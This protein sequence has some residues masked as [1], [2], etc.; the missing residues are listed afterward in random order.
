[1][2]FNFSRIFDMWKLAIALAIFFFAGPALSATCTF[3]AGASN[4]GPIATASTDCGV[5]DGDDLFV[6]D[7]PTSV[8]TVIDDITFTATVGAIEGIQGELIV[9]V[10]TATGALSI[11]LFDGNDDLSQAGVED[12][13]A[14]LG[15]PSF[16]TT[17]AGGYRTLGVASPVIVSTHTDTNQTTWTVDAITF[18]DSDCTAGTQ[19][20]LVCF[21]YTDALNDSGS[22]EAGDNHLDDSIAAIE[23]GRDEV[24]FLDPSMESPWCYPVTSEVHATP[25]KICINTVQRGYGRTGEEGTAKPVAHREILHVKVNGAQD[26][27]STCLYLDDATG[28]DLIATGNGVGWCFYDAADTT[29][30]LP[31]LGSLS[32]IQCDE[33]TA[34]DD[35]IYFAEEQATR[36]DLADQAAGYIGPCIE[37]GDNFVV[38]APVQISVSTTV[39]SDEGKLIFQGPTNIAATHMAGGAIRFDGA[40]EDIDGLHVRE[41]GDGGVLPSVTLQEMGGPKLSCFTVLGGDPD[42][43]T[44]TIQLAL[45]DN[46]GQVGLYH[47]AFRYYSDDAISTVGSTVPTSSLRMRWSKFEQ[48]GIDPDIAASSVSIVDDNGIAAFYLTKATL[49]DTVCKDCARGV[50]L[51]RGNVV[52]MGA[53]IPLRAHRFAIWGMNSGGP[54]GSAGTPAGVV[55]DEV[56]Y[57]EFMARHLRP[58]GGVTAGQLPQYIKGCDVRDVA[59]ADLNTSVMTGYYP[60]IED[61]I[62]A[63]I[64][65]DVTRLFNGGSDGTI[66]RNNIFWN[67]DTI[68]AGGGGGGLCVAHVTDCAVL[69][70]YQD[71]ADATT[72][73]V[74][75]NNVFGWDDGDTTR[76]GYGVFSEP[77]V[78]PAVEVRFDYGGNLV[79]QLN[80]SSRSN[81]FVVGL[82]I[83]SDWL[84]I[85][86]D[87][88]GPNCVYEVTVAGVGTEAALD[89]PNQAVYTANGLELLRGMPPKFISEFDNNFVTK[90]GSFQNERGCGSKVGL[91]APGITAT[92]TH[93]WMFDAVGLDAAPISPIERSRAR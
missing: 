11:F 14:Y 68:A 27:G 18:C 73:E 56:R 43:D 85:A 15:G 86:N 38:M 36:L 28:D 1:M 40:I 22:G 91:E 57:R 46:I 83:D 87:N 79:Y 67:N 41:A 2:D 3:D 58:T 52:N 75:E 70:W 17:F 34:G 88:A 39:D 23:A 65:L 5:P 47:S 26:A 64:T 30:G 13:I 8:V 21:D 48:Y 35:S 66:Y 90:A 63:D 20:E 54:G 76:I 32:N 93:R 37:R 81:D 69:Y 42:D 45:V 60:Q 74:L 49:L 92:A 7:D 31:I 29:F 19:N 10:T 50:T 71:D 51:G 82:D 59:Y 89:V 53:G 62:F 9:P 61:C 84:P 4:W 44:A 33:T 16:T 6:I 80:N 78:A 55:N 12:D 77:L 72:V 25:H 24:C